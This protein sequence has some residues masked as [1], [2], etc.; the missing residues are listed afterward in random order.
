ML[1][2]ILIVFLLCFSSTI[3]AEEPSDGKNPVDC[4]CENKT[5]EEFFCKSCAEE[6]RIGSIIF[7]GLK[8]RGKCEDSGGTD[9][10]YCM[11]VRFDYCSYKNGSY[12]DCCKVI[13]VP[14]YNVYC[15]TPPV[16]DENNIIIRYI[17]KCQCYFDIT[18][19]NIDASQCK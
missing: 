16:R 4:E 15:D 3:F 9:T 18:G 1:K 8:D 14:F 10:T 13:K 5:M 11:G 7:C 17:L 6:R 2:K 12:D 19:Q